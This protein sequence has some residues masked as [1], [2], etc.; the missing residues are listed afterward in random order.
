[1]ID[2]ANNKANLSGKKYGHWQIK[3]YVRTVGN[4]PT[5]KCECDCGTKKVVHIRNLLSGASKS[6]GCLRRKLQQKA[7]QKRAKIL[8]QTQAKK[9]ARSL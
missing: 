6:C 3:K 7:S 5:Y 8:S 1:M 4:S 9:A 2:H